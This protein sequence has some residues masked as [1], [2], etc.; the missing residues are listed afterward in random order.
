[1]KHPTRTK[2]VLAPLLAVTL[3]TAAY[4][5]FSVSGARAATPTNMSWTVSN[6]Q[7]GVTGVTYSYSFTTATAGIIK[8]ITFAVSG[9]GLAGTPTISRNF[10]IGAGTV[11]STGQ[12]ITYTITSAVSVAA[13]IPIYLSFGGLTNSSTAASYT[14][15]I[16][17]LTAAPATIDT[18][19]TP[20]VTLAANNTAVTVAVAQEPHLHREQHGFRARH[21]SEPSGAG[22]PER[23][24]SA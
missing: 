17:T 15:T 2:G 1:M 16:T 18:G 11:S 22:R 9:S 5:A 3:I 23:R 12:T 10:G 24:R 6:N 13:G 4:L 14:T 8:S 20:A 19:T 7:I 21:G